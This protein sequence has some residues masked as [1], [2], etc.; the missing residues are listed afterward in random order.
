MRNFFDLPGLVVDLHLHSCPAGYLVS[1]DLSVGHR[2]TMK[3]TLLFSLFVLGMGTASATTTDELMLSSGG[4][5]ATITDGGACTSGNTGC[6]SLSG[7]TS[8]VPGTTEVAGSINGWSIYIA[9]GS[10]NSP[11]VTPF[12]LDV[13][14]LTATCAGLGC[15]SGPG[16]TLDILYSDINFD[17]PIG[18]NG[19]EADY[20][21]TIT[22]SGGSTSSSA[23]F[24]NDNAIFGEQTLIGTVGPLTATGSGISHGGS[25]AA[26]PNYSMTIEEAFTA[27]TTAVVFSV[28]GNLTQGAVPEPSAVILFGTVLV[29]FTS[30]L[31]RHRAS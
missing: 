10:S 22:G 7:D 24:S 8:P 19:F 6:A 25:I 31:C 23:Y 29:L 30:K 13:F 14:S 11:N 27:S 15:S 26:V 5:T 18:A 21:A 16:G 9:G 1:D 17:V 20:S 4:L 3:L 12:G 28:D 2:G